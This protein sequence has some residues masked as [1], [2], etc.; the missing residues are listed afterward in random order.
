[1]K[2]FSFMGVFLIM[3]L[4]GC[5]GTYMKDYV[6]PNG[7]ASEARFVAVLPLVNL[8]TT[9]NA[10]RIVSE[11][12]STELYSSTKF[13]LMESTDMLKRVRGDEDDLDFVMDDVV[14][15]KMGNKLGVDTVIYGSVSEYQ[16][17]RGVNQ[18]PTVGINLRM[19]DVSSGKVLWASSSSQSGGCFFGC[20]ESLNSVAQDVLSKMVAAM[21]AVPAQ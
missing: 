1:M 12:L 20:T 7:I 10:G 4:A 16:Y 8:T 9:P 5:S 14:A 21:S 2:K 15:Q 18:S 19:I 3:I 11:L 6:Q 17:K 13:K